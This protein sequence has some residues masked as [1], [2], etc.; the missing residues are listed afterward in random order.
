MKRERERKKVRKIKG[1][2]ETIR[3]G[4]RAGYR[5]M[6]EEEK[7]GVNWDLENFSPIFWV[8]KTI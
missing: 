2:E 6:K 4:K 1:G 8:R 5:Q 3:R 7:A